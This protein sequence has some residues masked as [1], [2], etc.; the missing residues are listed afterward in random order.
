MGANKTVSLQVRLT[1]AQKKKLDAKAAS[2]GVGTSTWLLMLG[3]QATE[4]E[5]SSR[6]PT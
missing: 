2:L 5:K 1:P 3:L 6:R 4:D